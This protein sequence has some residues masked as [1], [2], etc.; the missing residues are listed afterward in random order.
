MPVD[1]GGENLVEQFDIALQSN[2]L[3]NLIKML[4]PHL[5]LEFGIVQQQVGEFRSL[6][7][8]IDLGHPFGLAFKFIDRNADKFRQH[9]TGIIERERL[10]EVARENVTPQRFICHDGLI[11]GPSRS[12]IKRINGDYR[13]C[14]LQC[15]ELIA[16]GA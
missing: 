7:H 9:V 3:A 5:G 14:G 16:V 13:R 10:V 15:D 6:L 8:Q 11:R 12:P 1:A 4:F 2:A